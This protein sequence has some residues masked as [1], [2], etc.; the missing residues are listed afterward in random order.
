MTHH[1][2]SNARACFRP[3]ARRAI[4]FAFLLWVW[5]GP[6]AL[7][8]EWP[9][10]V[11]H[12]TQESLQPA[13]WDAAV[14]QAEA[15]DLNPDPLI[16]E[17]AIEARVATVEIAPG[18]R[19]DAWTYDGELPGRLVRAR[20]G[21]RLI[22]HFTNKLPQPT[23]LHWHGVRVPIQMDGVPGVSQPEV[24]PGESFTYDFVVPDA[25]LFWYH[26]HVMSAAQVGFGLYGALLVEDPVEKVGVSDELVIVLSDI[27]LDEHGHLEDPDS[28][29]TT[30]MAFGREGNRVLVNGR[31][32]RRLIARAGVPQR[33]RIVNTAKSRYFL[34]DLD[35]QPFTKIGGDGGLQEFSQ[36]LNTVVVAAGERVDLIVTPR[37]TPGTELTFRSYVFNRGYG[38][39][40]YRNVEESLFPVTLAD[41]P[42][43]SAP[44]LLPIRRAIGPLATAD[45]TGVTMN[46]TI[47][48][49][50]NGTFEYGINK[51]PSWKAKP[52]VARLGETQ[53][54][55]LVNKTAWSHPFHLHGF[56]FQVLDD[57]GAAVHPIEWKDTINVPFEKTVRVVVRFDDDRPGNWMFHCHILDHAEGGLMGTVDVG[58]V[59]PGLAVPPHGHQNGLH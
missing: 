32:D 3:P 15:K 5:E 6:N 2:R 23:T 14:K 1:G 49:L 8:Q 48:Q 12:A 24:K 22:V 46:L 7:A 59:T 47:D 21:N 44:R 11:A 31:T 28:G 17:I 37:G 9:N 29:G 4:A 56:F 16:V 39:T 10:A 52:F 26:P 25:G 40:E 27:G 33:W 50:P 30:G 55:T 35:G 36:E 34:L 18:E 43:Y 38:S 41:L 54:W 57:H 20:V 53:I 58:T 19:V 13:G 51:I 42:P 45:A